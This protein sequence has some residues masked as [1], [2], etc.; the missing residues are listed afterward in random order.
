MLI[1]Q[2]SNRAKHQIKA[3]DF[4][5]EK[6]RALFKAGK[7]K[8]ENKKAIHMGKRE[9]E[10]ENPNDDQEERE[11]ERV[12]EGGEGRGYWDR[13]RNQRFKAHMRGEVTLLYTLIPSCQ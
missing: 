8:R 5:E 3:S 13:N 6:K 10:G 7:S 4:E 9:R 11:R 1:N 12:V 2:L